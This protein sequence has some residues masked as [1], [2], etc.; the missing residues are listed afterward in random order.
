MKIGKTLKLVRIMK[1]LKQKDLADK[2]GI[3]PNYLS[4]VENDKREPSLS[5]IKMVSEELDVPLSFLFLDNIEEAYMSEEQRIIYEKLKS[6]LVEFQKLKIRGTS[7]KD[8]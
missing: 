5:F 2:L 7:G 6:L 1:G 4:A 8:T 3:S